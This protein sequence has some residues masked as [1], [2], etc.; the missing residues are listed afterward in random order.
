[1][2]RGHATGTK[3]VRL[4][5]GAIY[6]GVPVNLGSRHCSSNFWQHPKS[7]MR[8]SRRPFGLLGSIMCWMLGY[9]FFT[10]KLAGLISP[11]AIL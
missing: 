10:A 8:S 2:Q 9:R 6:T 3:A 5:S 7:I 4:T 11:I 1:M